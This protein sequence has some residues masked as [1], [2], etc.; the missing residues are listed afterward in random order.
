ML[1]IDEVKEQV[2]E[3]KK[4]IELKI[5]NHQDQ[6]L[7]NNK[8]RKR[9]KE[10]HELAKVIDIPTGNTFF[11]EI[12][13]LRENLTLQDFS[14]NGLNN[15]HFIDNLEKLKLKEKEFITLK[16]TQEQFQ[17]QLT[18]KKFTITNKQQEEK[19]L[20]ED[21]LQL[22]QRIARI[23]LQKIEEVKK[24]KITIYQQLQNLENIEKKIQ[25]EDLAAESLE[26]VIALIQKLKERGK[27][28]ANL[29]QIQQLKKEE[30]E[31][32]K[33]RLINFDKGVETETVFTCTKIGGNCPF[34]Q[35]I[36]KQHFS[37]LEQQRIT[38][39]QEIEKLEASF[40]TEYQQAI[41]L[42]IDRIK[43]FL[44]TINFS[45]REEKHQ[46]KIMAQKHMQFLDQQIMQMETEVQKLQ[47][48][49]QEKSALLSRAEENKKHILSTQTE[50]IK[51]EEENNIFKA[52]LNSPE[53]QQITKQIHTLEQ[54]LQ[55]IQ[56]IEQLISDFTEIKNIVKHLELR[57][58]KLKNLYTILSKELLFT[59]LGTDLPILS[60]IINTYLT[61]VVDYQL[62]MFVTESGEK[63]ELEV[64]IIDAKG[65]REVKSLSG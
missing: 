35:E 58:E 60:E 29:V 31:K 40:R 51:L 33:T 50:I 64:K 45:I 36:N 11:D 24:E 25:F 52:Q 28:L 9:L 18:E 1:G 19:K 5:K 34:I 7:Q 17:K 41:Q 13:P 32:A 38:M 2:N 49:Q 12:E 53:V 42:E 43:D 21:I 62:S 57:R 20:N 39:K 55:I 37:Q 16:A 56:N 14:L 63:I 47:T 4:Q 8:L 10:A 61:Q 27:E 22:E 30:L 54:F 15:Q 3:E 44:H 48:Y 23:D 6:T 26:E 65:E 46:Q 59:A